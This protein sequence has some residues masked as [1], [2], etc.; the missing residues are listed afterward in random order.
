[1]TDQLPRVVPAGWY[2]DPEDTAQLRWWNGLGWTENRTA[3]PDT[4]DRD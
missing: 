1:M 2:E 3:R 4:A